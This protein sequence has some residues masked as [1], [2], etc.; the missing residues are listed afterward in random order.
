MAAYRQT[1]TFK[2]KRIL[3]IAVLIAAMAFGL[4]IAAAILMVLY[5]NL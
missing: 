2:L 5:G 1:L 4:E 3:L